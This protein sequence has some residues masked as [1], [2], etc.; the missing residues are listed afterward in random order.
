[1]VTVRAHSASAQTLL[2]QPTEGEQWR[3][4]E[5]KGERKKGREEKRERG[6]PC[7]TLTV[8]ERHE[9]NVWCGNEEGGSENREGGGGEFS[10][11]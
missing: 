1:M 7:P 8:P 3:E 5:E 4:G 10:H 11:T 9:V 2:H 6:K